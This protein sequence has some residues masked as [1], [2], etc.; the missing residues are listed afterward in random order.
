MLDVKSKTNVSGSFILL[1][2]LEEFTYPTLYRNR[3]KSVVFHRLFFGG[4]RDDKPINCSLSVDCS[5]SKSITNSKSF[6]CFDI[7]W[8]KIMIVFSCIFGY[9]RNNIVFGLATFEMLYL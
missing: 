3:K 6:Y 7:D 2:D 1:C 9:Q 5:P 4:G 8:L